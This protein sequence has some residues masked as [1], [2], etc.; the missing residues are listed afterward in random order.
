MKLSGKITMTS[1][2]TNKEFKELIDKIK[3]GQETSD[4]YLVFKPNVKTNKPIVISPEQY[5]VV[6]GGK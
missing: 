2:F 4:K 5:K 1:N 3:S 6:H